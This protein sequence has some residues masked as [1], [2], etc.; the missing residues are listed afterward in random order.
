MRL[1]KF[2]H[3]VVVPKG[4]LFD[5]LLSVSYTHISGRDMM[6]LAARSAPELNTLVKWEGLD[7]HAAIA[8]ADLLEEAIERHPLHREK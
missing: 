3:V 4:T 8:A 6:A 1:P 5:V 7:K 2:K